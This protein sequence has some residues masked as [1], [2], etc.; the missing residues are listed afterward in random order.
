MSHVM[1]LPM[2]VNNIFSLGVLDVDLVVD[3]DVEYVEVFDILAVHTDTCDPE[4]FKDY[5]LETAV[6][7]RSKVVIFKA[8][9]FV[10][11]KVRED[12]KSS[13][14]IHGLAHC[15]ESGQ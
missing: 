9:E 13:Y 11:E 7:L 3:D 4:H 2:G 1:E 12:L 15:S 6:L 10:I 14:Q 5:E 8:L